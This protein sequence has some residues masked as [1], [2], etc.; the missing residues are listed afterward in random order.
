MVESSHSMMMAWLGMG[1]VERQLSRESKDTA[2]TCKVK[3]GEEGQTEEINDQ[4]QGGAPSYKNNLLFFKEFGFEPH[5]VEFK[6]AF[7]QGKYAWKNYGS[8]KGELVTRLQKDIARFGK[9]LK[10]C[11]RFE[12]IFV[13]VPIHKVLKWWDSRRIVARVFLDPELRLFEYSPTSL[14]DEVPKMFA[15]PKLGEVFSTI[16]SSN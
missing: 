13:F 5:V 6:I 4:V 16:A 2:S 14:L 7:G 10:W 1:P 15:F 3:G 12:P 11:Y 8:D 9:A